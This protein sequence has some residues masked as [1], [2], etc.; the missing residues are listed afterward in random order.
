MKS[1]RQL[2]FAALTACLLLFVAGCAQESVCAPAALQATLTEEQSVELS[3]QASTDGEFY[4][5]Y[6]LIGAD[7]DYRFLSDVTGLSYRDTTA[8]PGQVCRYKVTAMKGAAESEGCISQPVEIA[9]PGSASTVLPQ[10][11]EIT[12]VTL[13]D[14]YTSVILFRCDSAECTYRVMRAEKPEGPF[15]LIGETREN[16][17]YDTTLA[18]GENYYYTVTAVNAQTASDPSAPQSTGTNSLAVSGTPVLMYHQFL[19]EG[20]VAS[21][22]HFGEYAIWAAEF[23]QDL[24]W[25]QKNGYTTVTTRELIQYLN[26]EAVPPEKPVIITIDDG[27]RGVYL[28][29]WPLLQKYGMKAVFSVIGNR[30]DQA[31]LE[32]ADAPHAQRLYC[33]WHELSEMQESGY[34]E[35][36]SHTATCHDDEEMTNIRRGAN[37]AEGES[38]ESFY[39][40]A[41]PDYASMAKN[42]RKFFGFSP[43][44]MSYPYSSRSVTSDLVWM[45]CGYEILFA[46]NSSDARKDA[47]NRFA[48]GAGVTRDS[49]VLRRVARMHGTPLQEYAR[50]YFSG[51]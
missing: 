34:V 12:S 39:L 44:A 51:R 18:A 5:V 40:A 9:A 11:P 17:F 27:Y 23:E 50:D 22:I 24:Q 28:N 19:T 21:G 25:L 45:Q 3:W 49:A 6:R 47:R 42:F 26:G 14:K 31:S 1:I 29:A 38:T 30:I 37:C 33:N 36:I 7:A 32:D 13:L 48:V 16:A 8:R 43:Y 2:L 46:G 10:T 35:I 20:D 4:R 41:L 15:T